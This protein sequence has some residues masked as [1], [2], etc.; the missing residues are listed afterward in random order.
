MIIRED[1]WKEIKVPVNT[2]MMM[3]MEAANGSTSQLPGCVKM[4]EINVDGLKT[5]AHA[6]IVP[7]AP[8]WLLLGRPWH[9]LVWL[10]QI[11]TEELVL[12]TI[13][14]PCN[15]SNTCTCKTTTCSQSQGPKS[16]SAAVTLM[17]LGLR[18]AVSACSCLSIVN[19]TLADQVLQSQYELDP[20]QH[21][22]TYKKVANK[23]K[24]VATTMPSAA[25]I[26]C[27]FPE[28]PLGSLPVV[29]S[30]P[31]DFSPGIH[32]TQEC[33]EELGILKN[34]FLWPEEK[35][36]VI[37]VLHSNELGLAWE[38]SEK[39][40]F[41]DDYLSP[42]VIPTVE[43]VPWVH[44]QPPILPGIREE[45]IK[46]IQKKIDSGVYKPSNSS[47]QS[48][49]FCVAKKNRSVRIMHDLQPLN[50]VTIRDA[51][52]L[53]YVKHFAEQSAG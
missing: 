11:E 19:Q 20:V 26:H 50:V 10:S 21:V 29:S 9:H 35:K 22:L 17:P 39:G 18:E 2:N 27:C 24:P 5:W 34:K 6:Y 46:L 42:V 28:D 4:L 31:P 36:L 1:L 3:K 52:T 13:H 32:L 47:Y 30:K 38:E 23:V 44:Q 14:D 33:L 45:V 7:S 37:Q 40:R 41:R 51:A 15:P 53:P 12:V 43:H 25:W 49:W 48:K 16:F 8:Y